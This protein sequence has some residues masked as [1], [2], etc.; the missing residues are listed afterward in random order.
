V[1]RTVSTSHPRTMWSVASQASPF[2]G[3]LD[4]SGI[5]TVGRICG[6]EWPEDFIQR[7]KEDTTEALAAIFSLEPVQRDHNEDVE[8]CQW[9]PADTKTPL[10]A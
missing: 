3:L 5:L 10:A 2:K 1:R 4:G 7:V 6:V 9:S 8:L